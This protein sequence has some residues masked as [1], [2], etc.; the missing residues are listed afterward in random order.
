[1]WKS[2]AGSIQ[3]PESVAGNISYFCCVS[4]YTPNHVFQNFVILPAILSFLMVRCFIY[5]VFC[6]PNYELESSLFLSQPSVIWELW[7]RRFRSNVFGTLSGSEPQQEPSSQERISLLGDALICFMLSSS[8]APWKGIWQHPTFLL[9]HW[10]WLNPW[11]VLF[12]LQK[13]MTI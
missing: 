1:M 9:N 10:E 7:D 5:A 3:P 6:R 8:P 13:I 11:V 2:T 12:P 4:F